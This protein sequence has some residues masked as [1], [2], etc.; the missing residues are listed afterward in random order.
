MR[1]FLFLGGVLLAGAA[2]FHAQNAGGRPIHNEAERLARWKAVEMPFRAD[3]LSVRE[4]RMVE[5]LVEACQLLDSVYWRQSDYGGLGVQKTATPMK[6]AGRDGQAVGP[7][8][9]FLG[10]VP[11]PPGLVVSARC[12]RAE[13]EQYLR[14]HPED[15]AAIYDPYTVV[16]AAGRRLIAVKYHE[17]MAI[18]CG[19]WRGRCARRRRLA[20]V[21]LS[22]FSAA[23]AEA[24]PR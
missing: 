10:E 16:K 11:M 18:C 14:Q 1:R 5:K 22:W 13:L 17:D 6:A 24:L 4:R 7:N 3:G 9:F 2:A 12:T 23:R 21:R 19:P 20:T 8:R 15:K